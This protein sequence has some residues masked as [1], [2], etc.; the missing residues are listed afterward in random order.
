MVK[1]HLRLLTSARQVFMAVRENLKVYR[2]QVRIFHDKYRRP[3]RTR[4][5]THI[6]IGTNDHGCLFIRG[7]VWRVTSLKTKTQH[8]DTTTTIITINNP[9]TQVLP[10]R[11]LPMLPCQAQLLEQRHHCDQFPR[12]VFY[13]AL[14]TQCIQQALN[15][16][17]PS[18]ATQEHRQDMQSYHGTFHGQRHNFNNNMAKTI[19]ITITT[20][21]YN[22]PHISLEV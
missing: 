1:T 15:H 16:G 22:S 18:T 20:T 14:A 6:T 13:S 9:V 12:T 5:R 19:T 4:T 21:G 10:H 7:V 2:H 17:Y 11:Q 3:S 8:M